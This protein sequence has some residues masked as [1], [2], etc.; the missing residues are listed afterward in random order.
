[1]ARYKWGSIECCPL[2]LHPRCKRQFHI[3][4]S[5]RV[6]R[7]RESHERD[8]RYPPRGKDIGAGIRLLP[9]C[10]H[11]S[12]SYAGLKLSPQELMGQ[13]PREPP[14][15]SLSLWCEEALVDCPQ[16]LGDSA[17]RSL[18]A[19]WP[20]PD[21]EYGTQGGHQRFSC[22]GGSSGGIGGNGLINEDFEMSSWRGGELLQAMHRGII[23]S[24]TMWGALHDN[25]CHRVIFLA[26]I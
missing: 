2:L 5:Y 21:L 22:S 12:R 10:S 19:D 3:R 24:T 17:C 25:L 16:T 6:D 7:S 1:M 9:K 23:S 20:G 15:L 8:S 4:D 26:W 14:L 11:I 18:W 13:S